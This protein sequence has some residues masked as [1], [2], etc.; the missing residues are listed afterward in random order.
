MEPITATPSV[1]PTWRV[2]SLT[3]EPTPA[4]ASGRAFM[5]DA[6]AGADVSPSP[7]P[8]KIIWPAIWRYAVSA[9]T[10]DV[11]ANPTAIEARPAATTNRGP[12]PA[13]MR[14]PA[15]DAVA[16]AIAN[17]ANRAPASSGE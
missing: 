12:A 9:P 2:V 6:V 7:P 8:R 15:T 17:G 14:A 5:M 10:V 13:A 16:V 4:F 1:P 11:Q 3:A